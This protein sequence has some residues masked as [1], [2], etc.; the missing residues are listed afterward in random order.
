M[1]RSIE[2]DEE[3]RAYAAYF[4]FAKGHPVDQLAAALSGIEKCE[5]LEY[6]VLRDGSRT[7][8]VYRIKND[9]HLHRL[10][11]WPASLDQ[12]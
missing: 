12:D 8:A 10:K 5:G 7:L 1:A 4:R 3:Q 11:R 2:R 6:V 9:G